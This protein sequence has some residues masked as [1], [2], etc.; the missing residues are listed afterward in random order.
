MLEA[1]G[2]CPEQHAAMYGQ[3]PII[4]RA[5]GSGFTGATKSSVGRRGRP[6]VSVDAQIARPVPEWWIVQQLRQ[7][8]NVRRDPP[9]LVTSEQLNRRALS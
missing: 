8:G 5:K 4:S 2:V 7:L 9:R 3:I 1:K 6:S